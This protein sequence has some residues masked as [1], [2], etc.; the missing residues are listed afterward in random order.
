MVKRKAPILLLIF[1]FSC[2]AVP[3]S[4]S[5]EELIQ[6]CDRLRHD[7]EVN[8]TPRYHLRYRK[9]PTGER[10]YFVWDSVSSCN[11]VLATP[12][13]P[14][15]DSISMHRIADLTVPVQFVR[16]APVRVPRFLADREA[17]SKIVRS[18][19]R[20]CRTSRPRKLCRELISQETLQNSVV[21]DVRRLAGQSTISIFRDQ[22]FIL[23][24]D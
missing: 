8:A 13:D 18:L 11:F 22:A 12:L 20:D 4:V 2:L 17:E 5:S 14:E 19:F 3:S 24:D 10:T 9:K 1:W 23:W 7:L 6:T 16:P 15:T 21:L